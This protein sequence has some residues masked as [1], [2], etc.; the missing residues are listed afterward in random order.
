MRALSPPKQ[1]AAF[2]C[3]ERKTLTEDVTES[4]RRAMR[5]RQAA[6]ERK[7]HQTV[8]MLDQAIDDLIQRLDGRSGAD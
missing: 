8:S 6:L 3:L 2:A 7:D 4:L 5:E 1:A